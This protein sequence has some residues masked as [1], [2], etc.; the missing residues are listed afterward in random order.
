MMTMISCSES[1]FSLL[2]S[3]NHLKPFSFDTADHF[4][5]HDV[6]LVQIALFY[7]PQ[8]SVESQLG[9]QFPENTED[10]MFRERF[11]FAQKSESLETFFIRSA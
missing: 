3:R 1:F 2:R 10:V 9:N 7:T 5:S 4:L 11:L 6:W 8:S